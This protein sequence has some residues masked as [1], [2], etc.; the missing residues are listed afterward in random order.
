MRIEYR[1]LWIDDDESWVESQL[2]NV[3]EYLSDSGFVLS[4]KREPSYKGV[5]FSQF[6][7][8]AVDFNLDNNEKGIEALKPIRDGQIYT[9]ILF[10]SLIGEQAL[11]KEI[12][13]IEPVEG[14]YFASRANF[15]DK[16][17]KLIETTIRK[18]QE[19]NNLRGLVMAETSTLDKLIKTILLQKKWAKEHFT[20]H[21]RARVNF[22]VGKK[23]EIEKLSSFDVSNLTKLLFGYSDSYSCFCV[24]EKFISE[25]DWKN[26]QK[27]KE[28]IQVRNIL[29]HGKEISS[30][31][32]KIVIEKVKPDG[33]TEHV[34]FTPQSFVELRKQIKE[35]RER[36]EKF[37][38]ETS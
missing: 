30:S 34:E 28:V 25:E 32:E 38:S 24:L 8:I 36:F 35:F 6:D 9:E 7:I 4:H 3:A 29:A 10:Y 18:T 22:H 14:V 13:K 21:H 15:S 37:L 17:K 27:Y 20:G 1:I 5:D 12:G 31:A 19:I 26:L 33:S 11:R 2:D 16:I 23:E